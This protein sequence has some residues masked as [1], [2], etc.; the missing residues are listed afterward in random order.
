VD[1]NFGSAWGGWCSIDP[2]WP[3]WLGLW[4]NARK[5]WMGMMFYSHTGFELGDGSNIRLWDDV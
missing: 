5:G 2:P 4:K 1:S 3:Y